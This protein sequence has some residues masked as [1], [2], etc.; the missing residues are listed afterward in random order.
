MVRHASASGQAIP[1]SVLATISKL[2]RD[3]S[4]ETSPIETPASGSSARFPMDHPWRPDVP[5]CT[6]LGLAHRQLSKIV[7]PAT[8]KSIT[9]LNKEH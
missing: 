4:S 7:A 6:E 3:R 8:P 9:V 5:D 1:S 2:D